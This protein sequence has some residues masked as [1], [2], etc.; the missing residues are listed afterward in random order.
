[1]AEVSCQVREARLG[2]D[3]FSVPSEHAIYDEGVAHVV[4][5]WAAA[6]L[7]RLEPRSA[8]NVDQELAGHGVGV[9]SGCFWVPEEAGR[10]VVWCPCSVASLQ[11][12]LQYDDY[13]R[14]TISPRRS[15]AQYANT[16]M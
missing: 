4:N 7:N 13:A 12:A 11:V 9:S 6:A 5:P 8:K 3:A 15:P 2:V 14:R 1:M 16:S 10:W